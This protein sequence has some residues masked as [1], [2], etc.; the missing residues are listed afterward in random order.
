[1]SRKEA[2]QTEQEAVLLGRLRHPNI[3]TFWESFSSGANLYIVMEFADGGD[4]GEFIKKRKGRLISEGDVLQLF[5]QICLAIKHTHDRKILH[6]DLKPQVRMCL[7]YTQK[8]QSY[9]SAV[10]LIFFWS[11]IFSIL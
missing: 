1:M 5:V 7:L 2:K 4:L 10:F 8:Q 11:E 3:V 9:L 6:R